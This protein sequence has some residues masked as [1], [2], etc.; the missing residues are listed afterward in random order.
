MLE[1]C[2]VTIDLVRNTNS[3]EGNGYRFSKPFK[4]TS[5][6]KKLKQVKGE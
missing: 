4:I 6:G 5:T 3:M 1:T 2:T